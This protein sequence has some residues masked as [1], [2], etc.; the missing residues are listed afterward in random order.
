MRQIK[1]RQTGQPG[2]DRNDYLRNI[3]LKFCVSPPD[4]V[5]L[6]EAAMASE[7][8]TLSQFIREMALTPP[9]QLRPIDQKKIKSEAIYQ[10]SRIGNSLNQLA[11]HCNETRAFDFKTAGEIQKIRKVLKEICEKL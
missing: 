6:R 1:K 4:N 5:K 9:D 10:V 2:F 3:T 11:K 8:N 7:Y